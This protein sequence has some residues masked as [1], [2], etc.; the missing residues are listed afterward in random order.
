MSEL[1][2]SKDSESGTDSSDNN[3]GVE[4]ASM[5]LVDLELP[6][7]G[8]ASAIQLTIEGD[9]CKVHPHTGITTYIA[10]IEKDNKHI[11]T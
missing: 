9:T 6:L 2:D 11:L 4:G 10:E 1:L 8:P 3:T 5:P 7:M